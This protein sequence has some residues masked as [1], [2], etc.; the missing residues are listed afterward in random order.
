MSPVLNPWP[1]EVIVD[2]PPPIPVV[3]TVFELDLTKTPIGLEFPSIAIWKWVVSL[4]EGVVIDDPVIVVFIFEGSKPKFFAF[5]SF[6]ESVGNENWEADTV[7]P[8]E[9]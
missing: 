7:F 3:L 6:V 1:V 9:T 4:A 2:D 8:A 5:K